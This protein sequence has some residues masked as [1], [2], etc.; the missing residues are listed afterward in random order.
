VRW[1]FSNPCRIFPTR[2]RAGFRLARQRH[3]L[4]AGEIPSGAVL[5]GNPLPLRSAP[6]RLLQEALRTFTAAP[7]EVVRSCTTSE[8]RGQSQTACRLATS[9]SGS[10]PELGSPLSASCQL[11]GS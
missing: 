9:R 7:L 2:G 1:A 3:Y 4:S 6:I 10:F 11:Q 8:V 5:C